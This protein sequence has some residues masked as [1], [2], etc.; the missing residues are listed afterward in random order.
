MTEDMKRKTV[1]LVEDNADDEALA[2][3]A[4]GQID[5]TVAVTVARDGEEAL[6][7]LFATGVR[8]GES[9][10]APDVVLLDIKLP[11]LSGLEVLRVLRSHE[12]TRL[13]PV[14]VLTSSDEKNDIAEGYRL[15]VNSYV[16][17]PVDFSHYQ[18]VVMQ[19]ARYWLSVNERPG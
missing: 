16:R 1:L 6:E 3:R 7:Y 14:V 12:A 9:P 13:Q 8:E 10:L 15:G 2:L 17:K 18:S 5:Q 11:K 4:L 19:L